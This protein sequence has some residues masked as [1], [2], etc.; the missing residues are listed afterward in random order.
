MQ[1]INYYQILSISNNIVKAA[2]SLGKKYLEISYIWKE[3]RV[4][5]TIRLTSIPSNI[6]N[7]KIWLFICPETGKHCRKLYLIGKYFSHKTAYKKIYYESQTHSPIDRILYK[8]PKADKAKKL[9]ESKYFR[10]NYKGKPTK[11]YLKCLKQINKSNQVLAPLSLHISA[12]K[13]K[14]NKSY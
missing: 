3:E 10:K 13:Q 2:I 14:I 12:L 5:S 9:I 1:L 4:E 11:R 7:G 8:F 6:G